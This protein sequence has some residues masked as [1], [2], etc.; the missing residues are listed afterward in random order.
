MA[1]QTP[2]S[3]D[4]GWAW[5]RVG[6]AGNLHFL[7]TAVSGGGGVV[8]SWIA[9]QIDGLPLSVVIVS[10]LGAA[11]FLYTLCFLVWLWRDER[12][13]RGKGDPTEPE[14]QFEALYD[15]MHGT[16]SYSRRRNAGETF[17]QISAAVAGGRLTTPGAQET[18]RRPA[19]TGL[20]ASAIESL[21]VRDTTIEGYDVAIEANARDAEFSRNTIRRDTMERRDGDDKSKRR[22]QDR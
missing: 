18:S 14:R 19:S 5:R 20:S 8:V 3:A 16:G 13:R 17:E 4:F 7:F 2:R 6:D 12:A 21:V 10:G 11:A 9:N 15:Q 1:N 22:P